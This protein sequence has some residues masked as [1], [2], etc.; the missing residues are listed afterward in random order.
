MNGITLY[1]KKNTANFIGIFLIF[2]SVLVCCL[3]TVDV[4]SNG[5][6]LEIEPYIFP[7]CLIV[8]GILINIFFKGHTDEVLVYYDDKGFKR[9]NEE[10]IEWKQLKKWT[11]KTKEKIVDDTFEHERNRVMREK[12][13]F[14]LDLL[15]SI[16]PTKK[17]STLK[18]QLN[19]SKVIIFSN[20]EVVDIKKFMRFLRK[21]HKE[22][23][24]KN[25]RI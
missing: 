12:L 3:G 11:L 21:Y 1:K 4:I 15:V 5:K 14:P 18:L 9:K 25:A 7:I 10:F 8:I 19:D 16:F 24:K 20:E 22:K 23:F 17:I 13:P 2:I 6:P